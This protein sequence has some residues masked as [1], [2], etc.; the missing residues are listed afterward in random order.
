MNVHQRLKNSAHVNLNIPAK[1]SVF[2]TISN[3]ISKAAAFLLTPLFTRLF[4]PEEYGEYS[5]FGS[6]LGI[7]IVIVSLELCGGVI[8]RAFQ[9]NK[10]LKN[11]TLLSAIILCLP[12]S[13]PAALALFLLKNVL[14]EG[15][16]FSYAYPLLAISLSSLTVINLY[17][18]KCKFLYKWIPYL[19][20][21]MMQSVAAP[22][23]SIIFLR[24]TPTKSVDHVSLKI[25]T[26][27]LVLLSVASFLFAV[28][29]KGALEEIRKNSMGKRQ[30]AAYMREILKF[31]LKLS[32]PLLP[33][34]F[35]V[36]FIS[37]TDKIVISE[38]FGK[39]ILGGYSVAY[40]AGI[41]LTAV[42]GGLMSSLSPWLMRRARSSDFD[43]I[44]EILN[45]VT[46]ITTIVIVIFLCVAPE[47]F[48]FLAPEEYQFALPITFISALMPI[49]LSLAQCASG[50]SI[51]KEKVFGVLISGII[52]MAAVFSLNLAFSQMEKIHIPAVV[53]LFGYLSLMSL[54]IINTRLKTGEFIINVNKTLQKI[55]FLMIFSA[56]LYS[57]RD[58]LVMRLLTASSFA[59]LLLYMLKSSL[60][61]LK[62]PRE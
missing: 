28:T 52:P 3:L 62:E 5:L 16:E 22:L 9:K 50:I 54:G 46:T 61:L 37:Q 27:T 36:M 14:G 32:L 10:E 23:L 56:F 19:I 2:F 55:L 18:S 40:S 13:F 49:P 6:Y 31:M 8:M 25:A 11:L 47:L 57:I 39:R 24:L 17:V 15:L 48:K 43:K 4:T 21:G 45:T 60:S 59:L 51:A 44:R 20:I 42:T 29:L 1:A 30:T 38:V 26:V 7:L 12:L 58:M 34:Y 41:A 53:T 35:S 33:Y